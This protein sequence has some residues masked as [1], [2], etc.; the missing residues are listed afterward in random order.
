MKYEFIRLTDEFKEKHVFYN[1]NGNRCIDLTELLAENTNLQLPVSVF[2]NGVML[3]QTSF[4]Y[5]KKIITIMEEVYN[6]SEHDKDSNFEFSTN[7]IYLIMGSFDTVNNGLIK[8]HICRNFAT[9]D[10][11]SIIIDESGFEFPAHENIIGIAING[12][13]YGSECFEEPSYGI[14]LGFTDANTGRKILKD[15]IT[16]LEPYYRPDENDDVSIL[17]VDRKL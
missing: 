11:N 14:D 4:T 16:F 7:R 9:Y 10:E 8:Q 15:R 5:S 1:D 2:I 3:K 12:V 13:I 6:L 17:V